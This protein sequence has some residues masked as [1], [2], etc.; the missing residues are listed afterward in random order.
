MVAQANIGTSVTWTLPAEQNTVGDPLGI[1]L[2][3]YTVAGL[4]AASTYPNCWALVTDASGGSPFIGRVAVRS[5]G[6]NWKFIAA[7]GATV[8]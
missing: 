3:E 8:S 5:D 2:G 7:E 4:P 6:T 1:D